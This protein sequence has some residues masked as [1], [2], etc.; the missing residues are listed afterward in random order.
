MPAFRW[1]WTISR[2]RRIWRAKRR[3]HFGT[4]S[5]WGVKMHRFSCLCTIVLRRASAN[6]SNT[7]KWWLCILYADNSYVFRSYGSFGAKWSSEDRLTSVAKETTLRGQ[8]EGKAVMD[9][10]VKRIIT[11][12]PSLSSLSLGRMPLY[13]GFLHGLENS[14]SVLNR[15]SGKALPSLTF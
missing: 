12:V 13:V 7:L 11:N 2:F 9:F 5:G 4:E 8:G 14:W 1:F 10:Y 6:V 3:L 15:C